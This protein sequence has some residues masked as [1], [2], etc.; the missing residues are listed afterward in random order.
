M[1]AGSSD[2]ELSDALMIL[3]NALADVRTTVSRAAGLTT[4]QCQLLCEVEHGD[5]SHG[6]LA[7]RLRCDKTN[8]TGLVGR[9]ERRTLVERR[10]GAPDRR[11]SQVVITREGRELVAQFRSATAA[12]FAEVF[13]DWPPSSKADL[14]RLC[15]AAISGFDGWLSG[16][17]RDGASAAGPDSYGPETKTE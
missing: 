6:E 11:V 14:T 9:L 17:P 15:L 1:T 12:V 13:A 4:Q 16:G 7:D 10:S 8:I 3:G 2:R 5:R